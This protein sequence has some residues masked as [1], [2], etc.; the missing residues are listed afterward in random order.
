MLHFKTSATSVLA[1]I[2]VAFVHTAPL[3][4]QDG[5]ACVRTEG[6]GPP[7]RQ[8][9][10]CG[11]ALRF[12]REPNAALRIIE[13]ADDPSPRLIEVRDGAIL[14]E[15]SPGSAPTQIRTP[16]AIATV[17]GTTYVV[18][19]GADLS[20]VFVIEGSVSVRRADDASTVTLTAGEGVDAALDT[21]LSVRRWPEDRAAALLARFGR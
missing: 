4:A 7:A 1:C 21:P 10:T 11:D 15:V 6:S 12:E 18:D 20:S 14:I 19:A 8:V 9:F 5:Q 13:R 17:R 2:V 3:V 16:H